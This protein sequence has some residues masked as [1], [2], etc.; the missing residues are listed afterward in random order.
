MSDTHHLTYRGSP[1]FASMFASAL[2]AEGLD[3]GWERPE[4]R[5]S[6]DPAEAAQVVIVQMVVKGSAALVRAVVAKWREKY[7]KAGIEWREEDGYR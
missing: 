2:E 3:V 1:P 7:P 6:L 4:E 5:R